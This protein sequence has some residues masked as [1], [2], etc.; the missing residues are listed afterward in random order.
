MKYHGNHQTLLVL[1]TKATCTM[2]AFPANIIKTRH[3]EGLGMNI[4][5]NV[6]LYYFNITLEMGI[7]S[8]SLYNTQPSVT[9][10][11]HYSQCLCH[12]YIQNSNITWKYHGNHQTLL[13]L[14]T[15]AACIVHAISG[16]GDYTHTYCK[17]WKLSLSMWNILEDAHNVVDVGVQV[18]GEY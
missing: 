4:L 14:S 13:V 2:H 11:Q 7:H 10:R 1:S 5:A 18:D 12:N 8:I 6:I 16:E 9:R 17:Q 3:L 15:K